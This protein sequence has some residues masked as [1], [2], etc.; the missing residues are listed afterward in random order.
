M[1]N[2]LA[3][4]CYKTF[5]R[6]YFYII[7]AVC[8]GLEAV[9][10]W[11]YWTTW[12]WGNSNV[13]FYSTAIMV[14]FMLSIGLY[15]TIV[16]G[17]I[18]FSEQYKN[19]TL[20]N[21]VSYGLSRGRIYLGKLL[22]STG[23]AV[24]AAVVMMGFY[25]GLCW[26]LF[27]HTELDGMAWQLI[28]YC[29]AG[30]FPL[31]LAAQAMVNT[32]YF[33]VRGTNIA[34]FTAAG[35][36]AVLPAILQAFGILF[37][38]AFEVLRQFMPGIM[39]ENLKNM[40]FQWNYVGLCWAAGLAWL[41][42]ATAV[43]LLAFRRKEIRSGGERMK[44]YLTAEWGRAVARP[45]FRAF[46]LVLLALAAGLPLLWRFGLG[47]MFQGSFGDS[48]SLLTPF[49]TVGLY[50]AVV[51]A[52]EVFSDQYK[53]DTLKNEVSF[54]LPRRRIYLGKLV[55]AAGIGLLLAFLT[56]LVYAVLCRVLLPGAVGDWVQIQTFLFRLLG[57]LPLWMG[58]LSLTVA[59]MFN[60]AHTIPMMV[61]V[62]A[63]L[64]GLSSV[65]RMVM[66]TGVDWLARGAEMLYHL[67]LTA[68]MDVMEVPLWSPAWLGWTWGVGLLWTLG[69]AAA[70][71]AL[72]AR[73]DIR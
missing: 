13:D 6:K 7:L 52:D 58:A 51:V 46:L 53:N 24:L 45:Y 29:L 36:L 16:T 49:F 54:G 9:L 40:A 27:P 41:V 32:C 72:F 2:Y 44:H 57:A 61:V 68:P 31:W 33:L 3:A 17:D 55:T 66:R 56:L 43:G 70:G 26:V 5:R 25:L 14:P 30:A 73:R 19:N 37:H 23:I 8:L 21:E 69:A 10:L 65:L 22:V 63:C 34:A 60:L 1:R 62:L 64:G 67:L 28:G 48:L 12:K 39:L 15:A 18:V 47:D 38:P 4:E 42:A 11:G 20:K 71:L 35:L 50:L 59:A